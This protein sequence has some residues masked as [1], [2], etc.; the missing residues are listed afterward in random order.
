MS[1][2]QRQKTDVIIGH[3][4]WERGAKYYM[5]DTTRKLRYFTVLRH[6]LH[7]K[8]SF[9]FHFFVRNVGRSEKSVSYSELRDFILDRNMKISSSSSKNENDNTMHAKVYNMLHTSALMR[10]AGPAYYASRLESD[11]IHGF[12]KRHRYYYHNNTIVDTNKAAIIKAVKHRLST[13]FVFIGLQAQEAAS[14]CMLQHT[15]D[16]LS[17]QLGVRNRTGIEDIGKVSTLGVRKRLNVGDYPINAK[18]V[19]SGMTEEERREYEDV[20]MIDLKIYEEGV[21]L[22]RKA[23]HKLGC[24]HLVEHKDDEY[25]GMTA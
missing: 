23:A 1:A 10:D 3:Q 5:G 21:A 7:R 24:A 12:N 14:L 15:V 22:F 25:M 9:F 11:G 2:A 16:A 18:Q 19:W 8:I 13:N 4:Y 17:S 20:E 6:P